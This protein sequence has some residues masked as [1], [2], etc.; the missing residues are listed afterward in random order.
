MRS[1]ADASAT[2]AADASAAPAADAGAAPEA[3][4]TGSSD[5]RRESVGSPFPLGRTTQRSRSL[6]L[7]FT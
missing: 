6:H 7:T 3:D 4:A 5:G 1:P 2:P